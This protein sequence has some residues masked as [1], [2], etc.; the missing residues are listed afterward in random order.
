MSRSYNTGIDGVRAARQATRARENAQHDAPEAFDT[1]QAAEDA[2]WD[3]VHRTIRNH[4][5]GRRGRPAAK[6]RV[7]KQ[8]RATARRAMRKGSTPPP[9]QRRRV[10]WDMT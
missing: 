7:H 3:E 1:A 8:D 2:A 9:V 10:G 5:V 4:A 6:R